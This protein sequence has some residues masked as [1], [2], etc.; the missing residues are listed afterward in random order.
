MA[1]KTERLGSKKADG[2]QPIFKRCRFACF[3]GTV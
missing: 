3:S 2:R 1:L